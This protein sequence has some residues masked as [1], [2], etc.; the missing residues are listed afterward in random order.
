MGPRESSREKVL[1]KNIDL[2][3]VG[4]CNVPDETCQK[5]AT[6]STSPSEEARPARS[7]WRTVLRI[8]TSV[9]A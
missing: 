9:Y 3:T 6:I 4:V 5:E 1:D 8:I 7:Q 2:P